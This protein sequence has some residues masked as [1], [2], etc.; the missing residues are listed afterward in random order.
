MAE[1]TAGPNPREVEPSVDSSSSENSM[2]WDTASSSSAS[3]DK[4][5]IEDLEGEVLA[6]QQR[7]VQSTGSSSK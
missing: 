6:E 3:S 4:R 2:Q 1:T 5:N 7:Q